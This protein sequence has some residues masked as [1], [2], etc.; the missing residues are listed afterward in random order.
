MGSHPADWMRVG[1]NS[2]WCRWRCS[3]GLFAD[4][5]WLMDSMALG[6]KANGRGWRSVSPSGFKPERELGGG[7]TR[8]QAAQ[9]G[10]TV[11]SR[12]GV[13]SGLCEDHLERPALGTRALCTQRGIEAAEL[14]GPRP[15]LMCSGHPGSERFPCSINI[16]C[17]EGGA[18][19][20]QICAISA[21]ARLSTGFARGFLQYQ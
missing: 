21:R 15:A 20:L 6:D 7:V 1:P 18:F 14:R 2:G 12:P 9:L 13:R 16:L 4:A 5:I 3:R 19:G 17:H 11:S 10:I 8:I